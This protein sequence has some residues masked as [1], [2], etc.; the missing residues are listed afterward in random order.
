MGYLHVSE[1]IVQKT[2]RLNSLIFCVS[3]FV[4]KLCSDFNETI[5]LKL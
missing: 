3:T 4:A 1:L 2:L 5:M